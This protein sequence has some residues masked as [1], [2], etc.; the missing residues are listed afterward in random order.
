MAQQAQALL[1]DD[2]QLNGT[3]QPGLSLVLCSML[4]V[5]GLACSA[6]GMMTCTTTCALADLT[7]DVEIMGS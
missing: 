2:I 5:H 3:G 1:E 6:D 4:H 7:L